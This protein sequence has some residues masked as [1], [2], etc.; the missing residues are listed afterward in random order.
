MTAIEAG[1][2]RLDRRTRLAATIVASIA[3]HLLVLGPIVLGALGQGMALQRPVEDPWPVFIEMEPRP[4]LPGEQA[5]VRITAPPS[6]T[7][8]Y[9]PP[10]PGSATGVRDAPFREP[11]DEEDEDAPTAPDPRTATTPPGPA[12][13][14]DPA[15]RL[16]P[17]ALGDR[18]AGSLRNGVPGCRAPATLTAAERARCDERLAA[19]AR[20]APPIG[21]TGDAERDALFAGQG[22]RALALYEARRAPLRAGAG[23]MGASPECPGGNLRSTCAGVHLEDHYQ[24]PENAPLR[25]RAGAQ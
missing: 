14:S 1:W 23:V 25:R 3:V 21:G 16:P 2:Q 5:R 7:P 8:S 17:R 4:L 20:R 22:V 6:Q 9:S 18:V 13:P 15:W 12:A 11:I 10:L 24:H 19:A